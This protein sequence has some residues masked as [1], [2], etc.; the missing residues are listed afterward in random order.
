MCKQQQTLIYDF[1]QYKKLHKQCC[2]EQNFMVLV[3]F[4]LTT[5]HAFQFNKLLNFQVNMSEFTVNN[6][7][8]AYDFC[9]SQNLYG[10][11]TTVYFKV[12]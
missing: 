3:H 1:P 11:D 9:E 6:K 8:W 2:K 4:R 5:T 7:L 10:N 12:T